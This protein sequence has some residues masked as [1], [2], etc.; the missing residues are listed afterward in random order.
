M[1]VT[2]DTLKLLS[3]VSRDKRDK[4]ETIVRR[5]V[6]ACYRNGFPPENLDRVY[7]EA[8]EIVNLEERFPEPVSEEPRDWEPARHYHQYV[9]PKAA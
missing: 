8:M 5:H 7:L 1:K 3:R 4:I 2:T 9:S 6:S